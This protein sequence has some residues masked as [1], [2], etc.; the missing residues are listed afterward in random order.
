MDSTL[1]YS[2]LVERYA[3]FFERPEARLR[4]LHATLARQAEARQRAE[5][6]LARFPFLKRRERLF[7]QLL[8]LWLYHLVFQELSRLLPSAPSAGAVEEPRRRLRRLAG[9]APL[10]SRLLFGCYRFRRPLAA[11]GVVALAASLFGV[12][13]GLAWSARRANDLLADFYGTSQR[14]GAQ[15][16]RPGAAYAQSPARALPDYRPEKVWL[17][18][19]KENFER[20]SNGARI[21]NDFQTTNRPRGYR[22]FQ[23]GRP[24]GGN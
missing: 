19:Q 17:V 10:A 23:N 2:K 12:Y 4:F 11:V 15:A 8:K 9:R 6:A 5:A 3:H 14:P 18:E 22:L 1:S 24:E 13:A 16:Q 7:E 20:Y 21:L